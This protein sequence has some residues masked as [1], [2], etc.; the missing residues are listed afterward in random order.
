[1]LLG[2]L[3]ALLIYLGYAQPWT[4]KDE[5]YWSVGL[6]LSLAGGGIFVGMQN[7]PSVDAM[8]GAAIGMA[9]PIGVMGLLVGGLIDLSKRSRS[10]NKVSAP[11]APKSS[12]SQTVA[13]SSNN[14][15]QTASVDDP[16]AILGVSPEAEP[17]VIT[18]AYKTM[19]RKHELDTAR[20]KKIIEAYAI[21]E[22]AEQGASY[23]LEAKQSAGK[24]DAPPSPPPPT[25][26]ADPHS[27]GA[28]NETE[29]Q[30]RTK[31]REP[32]PMSDGK[33]VGLGIAAIIFIALLAV[34]RSVN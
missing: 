34:A 12:P 13:H 27:G 11:Q 24:E 31:S 8:W 22:N 32:D 33:A 4:T 14:A 1:M 29:E 18:A 30:E 20:A 28:L 7:A 19:M 17:E 2:L 15:K 3:A 26:A 21:L 5:R 6:A 16:Y 9:L 23:D 10:K 25:S